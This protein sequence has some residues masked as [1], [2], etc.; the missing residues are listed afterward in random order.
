M[1]FLI[2]ATGLAACLCLSVAAIAQDDESYIY[3]TYMNCEV[4]EEDKVDQIVEEVE[5]PVY[6]AAVADGTMTGWGWLAHHTGGNWRRVRYHSGGSIEQLLTGLDVVSE[7]LDE[8][9]EEIGEICES[10]D[11]YIWRSVTGSGGDV[12]AVQRGKVG[13]STYHVCD[14]REAA[15]DEIVKKIFAPVY[16]EHIGEG[17]LTSWGWAEHIVG[18]KYRRLGTMTAE[19]WPSLLAARESILEAGQDSEIAGLFAEICY[20]HADYMWEIRHENP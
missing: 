3:V 11:D 5:K 4:A 19:D 9:S 6:D 1:N 18:G 12:L 10:H 15:A 17:K 16:D 7:R 8:E 2:K 20:S 13:L 14:T